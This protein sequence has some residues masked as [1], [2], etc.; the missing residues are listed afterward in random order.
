MGSAFSAFIGIQAPSDSL[1]YSQFVSQG[2]TFADGSPICY[3]NFDTQRNRNSNA[4]CM[5][6]IPCMLT[7]F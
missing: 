2:V 1:A 7:I 3:T 4:N 5:L 6:L